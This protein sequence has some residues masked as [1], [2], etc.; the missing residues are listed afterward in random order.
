[1]RTFGRF[2]GESNDMGWWL[3]LAAITGRITAVQAQVSALRVP[4]TQFA[5]SSSNPREWVTGWAG[6]TAEQ[7]TRPAK[8]VLER[9]SLLTDQLT[10]LAGI[11]SRVLAAVHS[12]AVD[13]YHRLAFSGTAETIF[14]KYRT[15]IDGLIKA[16]V[17]EVL[18]KLP[19]VYDRLATGDSESV[20][21]AMNSV[22]RIIRAFADRMYPPSD[23]PVK[24][25]GD[26]YEVGSD[27]VLNRLEL[28]VAQ[29]CSSDS[30]RNRLKR[31]LRDTYDRAS[32]ASHSEITADEARALLV[33]TYL[34][35]GEIITLCTGTGTSS[36]AA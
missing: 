14:E 26:T 32:A 18:E 33:A 22:R 34:L 29:H 25:G 35:V 4:D 12:F 5:P 27:K 19:T 15:V 9:F 3:P 36:P 6:D 31:C 23:T 10:T 20:S 30:R 16:A 21:Q 1:M 11:R 24:A 8:Q 28:L 13:H 17:P 7:V 2:T